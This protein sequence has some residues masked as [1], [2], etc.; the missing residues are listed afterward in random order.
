MGQSL[1]SLCI[2]GVKS[3]QIHVVEVLPNC[4]TSKSCQYQ[5]GQSRI[6]VSPSRSSVRDSSPCRHGSGAFACSNK[7]PKPSR[8]YPSFPGRSSGNKTG[9][10]THQGRSLA[11]SLLQVSSQRQ[12]PS[13][14][15]AGFYGSISN[16]IWFGPVNTVIIGT[17]I[18]GF[19]RATPFSQVTERPDY[20]TATKPG[21]LW[22]G[23]QI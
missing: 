14:T 5:H 3:Q 16:T 6:S 18:G 11:G 22:Q 7:C 12:F 15:P 20:G 9:S 23:F 8:R 4:K 21:P 19:L 10:F 17:A 1:F 2:K 13:L